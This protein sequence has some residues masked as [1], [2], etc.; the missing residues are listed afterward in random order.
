MNFD[1]LGGD[2]G[3][4][5]ALELA[6]V[7]RKHF[8]QC[9]H[10]LESLEIGVG[11]VPIFAMLMHAEPMTQRQLAE[12]IGVTPATVSGTLKRMERDGVIVRTQ[13]EHDAR[14]TQVRLSAKGREVCSGA[15]QF[16]CGSSSIMVKGFSDQEMDILYSYIQRMCANLENAA[17]DLN[18]SKG[19]GKEL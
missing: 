7:S 17:L 6:R 10:L 13:D 15:L 9:S 11:Q 3:V 18:D 8:H 12:E 2:R 5:I 14:I 1:Q 16:F 19:C 4:A